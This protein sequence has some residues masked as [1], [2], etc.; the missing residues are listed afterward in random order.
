MCSHKKEGRKGG[1]KE[2]RKE[3]REKLS[4]IFALKD[5]IKSEKATL[6]WQKIFANHISDK[7]LISKI[8]NTYFI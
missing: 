8:Y 6:E 1:R 2:G 3:E 7:G 5:T 4:K